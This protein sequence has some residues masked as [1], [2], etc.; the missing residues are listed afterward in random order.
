MWFHTHIT[1]FC[2]YMII[3]IYM[4]NTLLYTF[5]MWGCA[6]DKGCCEIMLVLWFCIWYILTGRVSLLHPLQVIICDRA[7]MAVTLLCILLIHPHHMHGSFFFTLIYL[8]FIQWRY[9]RK[10]LGGVVKKLL[11]NRIVMPIRQC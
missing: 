3:V 5:C 10:R 7:A 1:V 11:Q 8:V 9:I 2:A 4:L 6:Q